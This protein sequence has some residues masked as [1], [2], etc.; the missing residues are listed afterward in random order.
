MTV[1]I[2]CPSCDATL[3]VPESLLGK[4]VKCPKCATTF[5]TE[6]KEQETPVHCPSCSASVLVPEALL[7]KKVRCPECS[8]TFVAEME[9]ADQPEGIVREPAQRPS[10][11]RVPEDEDDELPPEEEEDEDRPRRR[12]R[13]R[14]SSRAA[15]AVTGPAIGIM[16]VSGLSIASGLVD[17]AFRVLGAGLMM[18]ASSKAGAPAGQAAGQAVGVILGGVFDVLSMILPVVMLL[19]AVKLKN[20]QSYGLALTSCILAILPVHCCCILGLPFGIWGLVVLN[21]P[22]VKDAFS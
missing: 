12:R 14:S 19:G 22:D 15:S 10:R 8:T 1:Q 2:P 5:V 9:D 20:L 13:R 21:N 16:V 11:S 7:G 3:R 18:G 17:L 4:S 6:R